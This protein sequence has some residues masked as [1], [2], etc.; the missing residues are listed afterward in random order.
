VEIL[1]PYTLHFE[2]VVAA[3]RNGKHVSVQKPMCLTLK[4]AD[5]MIKACREAGV[6]LKVFENYI[7]YPPY[8][9]ARELVEAGE[10]GE[11]VSINIKMG[12][13]GSGGWPVPLD[14]FM[15]IL[16]YDEMTG[17]INL[18]DDGYHKMSLARYFFGEVDVIKAWMDFSLGVIDIP[19]MVTW[20]YKDSPV[21][22][23]WELNNSFAMRVNS[24]YYTADER[25]EIAGTRGYIWVTRC[26]ARL[27]EIPPLLL[28]RDGQTT[29]FDDMRDDWGDAFHDCGW[30]FID[31]ILEDR[32]PVLSGEEGRALMQ[33]WLAIKRSYEENREVRL[34]E[35]AG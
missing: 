34:E 16:N 35:I 12:S 23:V 15:L 1:A 7:F 24:K 8:R 27:M 10:I 20:S 14:N 21:L 22:G 2:M 33:F 17:G 19:S 28:H 6:K 31:S 4:E 26:T 25:V 11:P 9:K 13:G 29:A 30:D 3:A 32:A 5:E 18:F